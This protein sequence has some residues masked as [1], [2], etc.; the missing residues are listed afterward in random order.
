[1]G[2]TPTW[3]QV[4]YRYETCDQHAAKPV[5]F[6]FDLCSHP[7]RHPRDL[8]SGVL[9]EGSDGYFVMSGFDRGAAFDRDGNLLRSFKG[10]GD[11]FSNFLQAVRRRKPD[12]TDVSLQAGQLASDFCHVTNIAYRLGA[13]LSQSSARLLEPTWQQATGVRPEETIA[14]TLVVDPQRKCFPEAPAANALLG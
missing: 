2:E 8:R 7:S 3:L 13:P 12:S 9:F 4:E 5:R 10:R 14:K 11:P 1:M 6:E